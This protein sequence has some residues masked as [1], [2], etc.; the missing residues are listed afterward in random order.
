MRV[1]WVIKGCQILF[2]TQ[3]VSSIEQFPCGP[4]VNNVTRQNNERVIGLPSVTE[5][6]KKALDMSSLF[7]FNSLT[8]CLQDFFI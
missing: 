6:E 5:R 1:L 2:L 8:A 7:Y 4:P 3:H